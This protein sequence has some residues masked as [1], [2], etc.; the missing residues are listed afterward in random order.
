MSQQC[1]PAVKENRIPG[2]IHKGITSRDSDHPALLGNCQ[3]APGVLCP[4]LVHKI[5]K[6]V[7]KDWRGPKE[8][9]EDR[10]KDWKICP[11][12]KD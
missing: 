4:V 5:Q 7:W 1:A 12:R 2:C 8:I 10:P 9:H 11:K 6:K 3:A